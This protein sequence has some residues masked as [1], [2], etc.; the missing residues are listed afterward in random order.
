MR[1]L[2]LLDLCLSWIV[3]RPA[4]VGRLAMVW[5][6]LLTAHQSACLEKLV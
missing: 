1:E 6:M 4:L 3:C 5:L 2:I